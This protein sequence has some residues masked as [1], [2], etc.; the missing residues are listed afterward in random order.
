MNITE[1][2]TVWNMG[3][4]RKK[5]EVQNAYSFVILRF[6]TLLRK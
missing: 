4:A 1:F 2:I 6:I 5:K 3:V